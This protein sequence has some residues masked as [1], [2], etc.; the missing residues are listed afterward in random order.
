MISDRSYVYDANG[1]IIA[2]IDNYAASADA[3]I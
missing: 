3:Y 2:E 1:N